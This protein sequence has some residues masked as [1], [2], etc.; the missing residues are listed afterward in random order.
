MVPAAGLEPACL[1]TVVFESTVYTNSIHAGIW[2]LHKARPRNDLTFR[3]EP[4]TRF[5]TLIETLRYPMETG[6]G[7][8]IRTQH[9]YGT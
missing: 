9:L 2:C 1:T 7:S 8:G 3:N 4:V 5:K 6:A